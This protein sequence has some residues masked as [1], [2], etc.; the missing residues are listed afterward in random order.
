[1]A[2]QACKHESD[3]QQLV[4]A[5]Q[6]QHLWSLCHHPQVQRVGPLIARAK[7]DRF[8]LEASWE[9]SLF[10]TRNVPKD[11]PATKSADRNTDYKQLCAGLRLGAK[12]QQLLGKFHHVFWM[13]DL[14]YRVDWQPGPLTFKHEDKADKA[15]FRR[16]VEQVE[17]HRYIQFLGFDQLRQCME[18]GLAFSGF[19]EAPIT[20]PDATMHVLREQ[21]RDHFPSGSGHFF[22]ILRRVASK[23]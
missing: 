9:K 5:R 12:R 16:F 7:S 14:N 2:D 19:K 10:R 20:W 4:V 17:G 13:G 3:L 11:R 22:R 1:M 15:L 23:K 18:D 6:G 21:K 8:R